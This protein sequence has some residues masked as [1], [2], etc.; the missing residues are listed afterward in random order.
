[1]VHYALSQC[2]PQSYRSGSF[3]QQS[4]IWSPYSDCHL[5]TRLEGGH[6]YGSGRFH[7]HHRRNGKFLKKKKNSKLSSTC[8]LKVLRLQPWE[9]MRNG[10]GALNGVLVGS[11]ISSLVPNV[12]NVKMDLKMWIF[13]C[14]GAITR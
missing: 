5:F 6:G 10:V 3:C 4:F 11:V 9:L 14:L 2:F 1:M 7:C 13:I 12:Y 8:F